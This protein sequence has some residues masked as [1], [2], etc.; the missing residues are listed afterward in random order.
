MWY[1]HTMEHNSVLNRDKI[2]KY[3]TTCEDT[4][5]EKSQTRKDKYCMIP[6]T[7]SSWNTQIHRLGSRIVGSRVWVH[8]KL[9]LNRCWV[10][11]WDDKKILE[12]DD[13][14]DSVNVLNVTEIKMV[15]MVNCMLYIFSKNKKI[16]KKFPNKTKWRYAQVAR[17]T[18]EWRVWM[19]HQ[20]L[21]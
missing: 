4:G 11:V 10:S 15:K 5:S 18:R 19:Q 12:M 1:V 2:L 17:E 8:R 7:Q 6:F 14:D 16:H 20:D 13:D 21:T 9:L 3:A